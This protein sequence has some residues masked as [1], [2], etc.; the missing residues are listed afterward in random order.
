MQSLGNYTFFWNPDEM[1]IPEKKKD[2]AVTKTYGGSAIFEWGAILQ[3]TKVTLYWNYM[4]RGMYKKLRELYIP[5]GQ[6]YEW[7]PEI[8]GNT[9]N[10]KIIDLAG[11]YHEVVNADGKYRP[12]VELT[13]DIR[14]LN[15]ILQST[16]TTTS[17]TTTV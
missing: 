15:T 12:K 14:S 17:T 2:I 5:D 3:G 4:P 11:S 8:G 13:L 7:N 6:V 16:S 10:V 1:T 9:Y